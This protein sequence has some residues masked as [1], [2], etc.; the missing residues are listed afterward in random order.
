MYHVSHIAFVRTCALQ[1]VRVRMTCV[2]ACVPCV[3]DVCEWSI[4]G[5]SQSAFKNIT[6]DTCGCGDRW[7]RAHAGGKERVRPP[8]C[9]LLLLL[10][11]I[12]SPRLGDNVPYPLRSPCLLL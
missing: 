10:M 8:F 9:L 4:D 1:C 5:L 3:H 6:C 2:R 11:M 7:S 12:V